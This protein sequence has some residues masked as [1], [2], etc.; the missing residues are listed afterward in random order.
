MQIFNTQGGP[1][2]KV[3]VFFGGDSATQPRSE[4][5]AWLR[6]SG[7]GID[8]KIVSDMPPHSEGAVDDRVDEMIRWADAA[9]ALVTPDPRSSHGAPNLIDE[10]G[11][12]RGG[13]SKATLCVVRQ[14]E[15]ALYS[16]HDGI[17]RVEFDHRVKEAFEGLRR[18]FD[19]PAV[20]RAASPHRVPAPVAS[21][22]FFVEDSGDLIML[23]SLVLGGARVSENGDGTV[24]VESGELSGEAEAEARQHLTRNRLIATVFGNNA[25]FAHV[26]DT[27]FQQVGGARRVT[28]TLR[29]DAPGQNAGFE[30]ALG[31]SG[32]GTLS[33][34]DIARLRT[35][36]ILLNAPQPSVSGHNAEALEVLIR[37]IN[38]RLPVERSPIPGVLAVIP[39]DHPHRWQLV[40]LAALRSLILGG[41]VQHV[42]QLRFT[43]SGGAI[44]H[45]TFRGTRR[46]AYS[47]VAPTILTVDSDVRW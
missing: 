2:L 36:R 10:I 16:N 47:N 44:T 12:W 26:T 9:I 33:A 40:R 20:A 22:T 1:D 15:V 35:N 7:S 43:I 5:L 34:D 45:V 46:A 39:A 30:M 17:V 38:S 41:C 25:I 11:R 28:V 13:R 23:D 31:M 8:A 27:R 21:E 18:F 24:V 4:L 37:G 32:S 3:V 29:T 42:S 6:E 19:S 14:R